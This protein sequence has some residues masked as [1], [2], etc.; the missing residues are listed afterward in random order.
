MKE[1]GRYDP[2]DGG[3]FVEEPKELDQNHLNFQRWLLDH[4]KGEH[5][6]A[7]LP[8]RGIIYD[9]RDHLAKEGDY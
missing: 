8:V 9:I 1:I 7:G 4:G 6:P 3:Q 2:M 5:E